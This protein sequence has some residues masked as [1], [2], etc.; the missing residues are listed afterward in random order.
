MQFVS[1]D[2]VGNEGVV[3]SARIVNI[4]VPI[5]TAPTLNSP[6]KLG[7]GSFQ[8]SFNNSVGAL[9]GVLSTTNL[10]LPMTNW[11]VAGSPSNIAPGVFQFTSPA[12]P[13]DTQRFFRVSSP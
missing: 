7:N 12:Y 5:P 1:I 6:Q 11:T 4:S 13:A 8:F 3:G 9:F 2:E 10:S